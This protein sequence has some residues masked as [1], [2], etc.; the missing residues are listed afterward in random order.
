MKKLFVILSLAIATLAASCSEDKTTDELPTIG[1]GNGTTD[2]TVD[3]DQPMKYI[4]V[5]INNGTRI[6]LGEEE[7]GIVPIYW[8]TGDQLLV[9]KTTKSSTVAAEYD[10]KESAVI[11]VPEDTTYPMTLVYPA[12][13]SKGAKWCYIASNQAYDAERIANGYGI[14]MGVA[15]KADDMVMLEHKCGYM[16]VSLTGGVTVKTVILRSIGHEPL[17]GYFR[18]PTTSATDGKIDLVNFNG[19]NALANGYFDSPVI[20]TDCGDGVM[21]SGE[22]TDFYFALPARTYSK[23]FALTI[24]DI[25]GKQHRAQA[26]TTSG[27]EVKAGALIKMPTL[28]VNCTEDAGIYN[29]NEF[30]GYVR[31]LEKNLWL[32][33]GTE[34]HLRGNIDLSQENFSDIA[35]TLD[36]SRTNGELLFFRTEEG[37][38]YN[39]GAITLI[40][41]HNNAITGYKSTVAA[42]T[43]TA[44]LIQ[45]IPTTLTIQNLS[46]GNTADD[47]A[48]QADEADCSLTVTT[49]GTKNNYTATVSA[50][51]SVAEGS[52]INCKNYA[53]V[54]AIAGGLGAVRV[55]AFNGGLAAGT[56]AITNST[57][58]GHIYFDGSGITDGDTHRIGGITP[59]NYGPLTNCEN[60]GPVTL[61]GT[62]ESVRLGGVVGQANTALTGCLNSGAV[63]ATGIEAGSRIGGVAGHADDLVT[64][65]T[66]T[67]N[68][69]VTTAATVHVGGVLG[70]NVSEA[71]TL[72]GCVNGVR[73]KDG[74][75]NGTGDTT[76]GVITVK[77]TASANLYIGGICGFTNTAN[78]A[79]ANVNNYAPITA[80]GKASVFIGGVIGRNET[81]AMTIK[82]AHNYGNITLSGGNSTFVGGIG[83]DI[84]VAGSGTQ[85]NT[86]QNWGH[87]DISGVEPDGSNSWHYLGGVFG[88]ID[89]GTTS[90]TFR[91]YGNITIDGTAKMRVGGVCGYLS[92][93]NK[94]V[95]RGNI[96]INGIGSE[97]S[98]GGL[99]GYIPAKIIYGTSHVQGVI[100]NNV[101]DAT[102]CIGGLF[103]T[104][105][106]PTV[107]NTTITKLELVNNGTA[108]CGLITTYALGSGKTL[109]LGKDADNPFKI[110]K[111]TKFLGITVTGEDVLSD[112]PAAG[113]VNLVNDTDATYQHTINKVAI[114]IVD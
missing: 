29:G 47:P 56:G 57:N 24:I 31:T 20:F 83:G 45:T 84:L 42:G 17:S 64:N 96:T 99:G 94:C 4:T 66:N 65:C 27:K 79:V 68:I 85:Y 76:K 91:N 14:L 112:N 101:N 53:T 67:G 60:A 82:T 18:Y 103:G 95:T 8:S 43:R 106:G 26:Y 38:T 97:S 90:A 7:N 52:I 81:N 77:Q 22:A 92:K 86:C 63:T 39:C 71:Q 70:T 32:N 35:A 75:S 80:T 2:S 48:T 72:D 87:I 108:R 44:L 10:G 113:K 46:L 58:Y 88:R 28:A 23:G 12:A 34:L 6:S 50:F 89:S 37:D 11:G 51:C 69:T 100:T 110:A 104:A 93:T 33:G 54:K 40:D 41:G 9:N 49:A 59:L 61:V 98:I 16:K 62:N 5:G 13:V 78:V 107:Y 74:D 105:N 73:I 15:E 111:S 30:A 36:G 109:T 55:G 21:L 114:S 3:G 102:V 25:N 19:T 1:G